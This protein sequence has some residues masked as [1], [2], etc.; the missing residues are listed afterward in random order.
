VRVCLVFDCLY[1]YTVGGGERWYRALAE[2]LARREQEVTYLTRLQWD[3]AAGADVPGVDVVAVT[4]AMDLYVEGR[5]SISVQVRFGIGVFRHLL[6]HGRSYDVVQTPGLHVSL[7]AV[8]AA[9]CFR[10]FELVVDWWEVWTRDYWSEYLGGLAGR[11]GWLG[12]RLMARSRHRALCFS[13]LHARRLEE[14]GHRGEITIVEGLSV[15]PADVLEPLPAEPLVVFAGRHI[16]EKQAPAIVPAV[17]LARE[18]IPALR[19]EIFGDGPERDEVL[20]LIED[21]SLDGAVA[22]PGFAAS[23]TVRETMRR[24]L[25]HLFPSRREGYGLVVVEAASLGVPTVAVRS[26]DNAALE[27]VEEGVNGFVADSAAPE[28]LADAIV[29]VDEAG[30]ELRR[31]TADWFRRNRE[32]L[33][34][35]TSLDT[36]LQVYGR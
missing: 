21:R 7:L 18:R 15:L 13:R 9:R 8:L 24:A 4:P 17:A 31:S 22:A 19:A 11:I 6:R 29:R 20:R 16:P 2:G 23:E 3:P 25:C 10:R 5:R 32:R 35:E 33:S 28:A 1:P 14:L 36:V 12:Q 34:L 30:P 27:L 26:P